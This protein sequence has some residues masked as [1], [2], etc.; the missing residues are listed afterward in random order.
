MRVKLTHDPRHFVHRQSPGEL[1]VWGDTRFETAGDSG[2]FDAWVVFEHLPFPQAVQ[3]DPGRVVFITGEPTAV[4]SYHPAFLAQFAAVLTPRLDVQ[5][6]QVILGQ[7]AL[8]WLA[9]IQYQRI[10]GLNPTGYQLNYDKLK[11]MDSI[12]KPKLASL[13][14][15]TK[16][17]TEGHRLRLQLLE[18]LRERFAGRIDFFGYGLKPI[19]DKWDA[20]APYRYHIVLENTCEKDYWSEK[21]ADTFLGAA[22]PI[23][24]GCPNVSDYFPTG[25][26]L[27]IDTRDP[28]GAANV[29]GKILDADPYAAHLPMIHE[30]RT[31][32]LD[33]YNLYPVMTDLLKRLSVGTPRLVRLRPENDYVDPAPRRLKRRLKR[34]MFGAGPRSG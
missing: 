19:E 34:W 1:G 4:R 10:S 14:S 13:I 29:I 31:L 22:F 9:G 16:N 28:I 27:A 24:G 30:A 17:W 15:T 21:L 18:V 5:H 2:V 26:H 32:V 25:S 6:P 7:P 12:P 33:R 11:A 3:C 20:I 8:P 23:Y